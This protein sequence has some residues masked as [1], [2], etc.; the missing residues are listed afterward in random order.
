MTESRTS[1]DNYWHV[2]TR[3]GTTYLRVGLPDTPPMVILNR[4]AREIATAILEVLD[5]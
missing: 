1:E 3:E 5:A 2:G 4:H